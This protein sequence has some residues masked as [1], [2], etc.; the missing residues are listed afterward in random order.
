MC[1]VRRTDIVTRTNMA[2]KV[3][4]M[5]AVILAAG[6]STRTYPLTLTV[7]KVLIRVAGKSLLEHNLE[8]LKGL[9]DE[10]VLVV[11]YR[12]EMVEKALGHEFQGIRLAYAE[13]EEQLGTGHAILA[14]EPYT[15]KD[16]FI[17]MMGDDIYSRENVEMLLKGTPSLL[18]QGVEDP[19]SF[20]V[21]T[22]KKGLVSGFQEKPGKAKSSLANCGLYVL[23]SEV[24]PHIRKLGK[25]HRGE[26]ELNEAVNGLAMER[27]VR[28]VRATKGWVP[29][30]YPWNLLEANRFL[31]G[32]MEPSMKG[33]VE[34]GATLK[35]MVSVGE[36]TSVLAGSYIEGPVMIGRD[37]LIGP[38]CYIRPYT[39]IG[40]GCRVGNASEVKN[41]VIGDGSKVPHL[42]YVGDSVIGRDVSLAAGSI[43]AN[44]R[45]D[46][47]VVKSMVKGGL[48]RTGRSKF[49]AVIGDGVRLGVRTI[50]YPGR[51]IWPGKTTLPGQVVDRDI[52]E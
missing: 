38:N 18:A 51:K 3:K 36:G 17:V 20:G 25:T 19:S 10:A 39:S 13:Q 15:G 41:S 6:K 30:G 45:H 22:E 40:D 26:Y 32:G 44:L 49:G 42:N 27:P 8:A 31:L 43:T 47:G 35:G 4:G 9:V 34:E 28:I 46:R 16:E 12:R 11:G 23:G 29:V 24:F 2:E 7:P 5:K 1:A 52:T 33:D 48:V 37:C 50:I 21:W 14:A